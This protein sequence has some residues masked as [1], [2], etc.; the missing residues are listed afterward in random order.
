MQSFTLHVPMADNDSTDMTVVSALQMLTLDRREGAGSAPETADGISREK[1]ASL[2]ERDLQ[3]SRRVETLRGLL[4]LLC[5]G[6]RSGWGVPSAH[7]LTYRWTW[8]FTVHVAVQRQYA[9][10]P[11]W[12]IV[13]QTGRLWIAVF[14]EQHS[15][16]PTP[17]ATPHVHIHKQSR[18]TQPRYRTR[19]IRAYTCHTCCTSASC[20]PSY[21]HV[22]RGALLTNTGTTAVYQVHGTK[23]G[24]GTA[25]CC[26]V[27]NHA[28]VGV[29]V[30]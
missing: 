2:L 27:T 4:G 30:F 1:L 10:A 28:P 3:G 24:R 22:A 18:P 11:I 5:D 15:L 12:L 14:N 29:M 9:A 8:R 21:F 26:I 13:P 25:L 16:R 6:K 19:I 7:H 20:T 23:Q 17:Q